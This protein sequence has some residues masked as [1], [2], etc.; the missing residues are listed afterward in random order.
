MSKIE[1]FSYLKSLIEGYAV[2][3]I[4]GLTL[5]EANYVARDSA[6]LNKS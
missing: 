4:Q 1:K 2:S 3:C 6:D 5:S